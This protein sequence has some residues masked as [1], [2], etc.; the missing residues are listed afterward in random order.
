MRC[1]LCDKKIEGELVVHR[2]VVTN[3]RDEEEWVFNLCSKEC[4]MV[5]TVLFHL[6]V[7]GDEDEVIMHLEDEHGLEWELVEEALKKFEEKFGE[8]EGQKILKKK[9]RKLEKK[10]EKFALRGDGIF[11][12][13]HG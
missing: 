4:E 2:E 9:I 11:S 6:A 3:G 12:A 13:R 7:M 1:W 5:F 10:I 8:K